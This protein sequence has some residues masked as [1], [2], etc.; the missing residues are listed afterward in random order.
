MDIWQRLLAAKSEKT[1]RRV[2]II[3]GLGMLPFY[4]IF[5]LVGMA[6]YIVGGSGHDPKETVWMFL[7]AHT[8][9]FVL[10]FAVVGLLSA[11]MSS[12]DSYLNLVAIS[13]VRDFRG[14]GKKNSQQKAK[15][16][17]MRILISTF[18]FGIIAMVMALIFPHIVDL[19]VIGLATI[20][21]FAPI[22]I[23]ALS[24]K[25]TRKYRK[26]ALAS[27]VSGFVVNVGVFIAGIIRP[28]IIEIKISFIPAFI[29]ALLVLLAG[30]M[31][32][33]KN[34]DTGRNKAAV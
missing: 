1:A 2:S 8:T 17:R 31:I 33:N 21:I 28:D 5:P 22:T 20:V 26:A 7:V 30:M 15:N 23:L 24:T 25:Q 3:S 6:V 27:I 16:E 14:W 11:L 19:M 12:G 9:P 13:S 34:N 32:I 18:I 10:G 29:T 4:V